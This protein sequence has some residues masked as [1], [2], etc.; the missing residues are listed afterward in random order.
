MS[1][2]QLE[3]TTVTFLELIGNGRVYEV[4]P[5]QRD[6]SWTVEQWEDLWED[7]VALRGQE[8][9][10]HYLG[11]I[12]LQVESDRKFKIIDGQQR[13]VTLSLF[14]LAVIKHLSDLASRGVSP[15]ENT[16]RADALRARFIGDK[17][18]ASLVE[19]SK[20]K[21]NVVNDSIYAD[22]IV[23]L[24]RPAGISQEKKTNRLLMDCLDFFGEKLMQLGDFEDGFLVA[25]LLSDIVARRMLLIRIAVGDDLSAYTIFETLNA[26]FVELSPTDLLKNYLFSLSSPI[27]LNHLQRRWDRIVSLTT[28]EKF[29][30]FLRYHLLCNHRQ[31]RKERLFKLVKQ[32]VRSGVE[33]LQLLDSLDGR[34]ALFQAMG[35]PNNLY[36]QDCQDAVEP[37]R[38]LMLFG[39]T[40]VIPVVFAAREKFDSANF[41]K[42]LRM[43]AVFSFRYTVIGSKNTRPLEGVYSDAA[44]AIL[45]GEAKTAAQVFAVLRPLYVPDEEFQILFQ[46]LGA[47]K[48]K[49]T[50]YILAKIESHISGK[51]VNFET[52]PGTIEHIHPEN[53][54]SEWF[55][56]DD[57][58]Q[59][60]DY[61][62]RIGNLTLL[63]STLNRRVGNL[64]IS[65]KL[66][67]YCSSAYELSR[68]LGDAGYTEWTLSHIR[69]R[70]SRL[71][72]IAV[73]VWRLDYGS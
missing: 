36:W 56:L 52:D 20:L 66:E 21:L 28:F 58:T 6:Y 19:S 61:L 49:Q 29:P 33:A 4:P 8:G 46:Q 68:E 37:V 54:D 51:S 26:R 32:E 5:Y 43:L 13:M 55:S 62:E 73:Q 22:Y 3:S 60:F 2:A 15:Q 72:K 39:V 17:D 11:A 50:K 48:K 16:E 59:V 57:Q 41:T 18:P 70:Q 12:V 30:E 40:Q 64:P 63:E 35:D 34:A 45:S 38:E 23:Q 47:K 67:T 10:V 42:V 53:P 24:K 25:Q 9:T 27:D 7:I 1:T 14:A 71:A 69:E 65:E 44:Q 31:I